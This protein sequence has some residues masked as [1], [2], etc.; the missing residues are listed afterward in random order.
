MEAVG[1]DLHQEG[2][3]QQL[4]EAMAAVLEEAVAEDGEVAEEVGGAGVAAEGGGGWEGDAG[5]RRGS[6]AHHDASDEEAEVLEV[7]ALFEGGLAGGAELREVLLEEGVDLVGDRD[8]LS[9]A[10]ELLEE[11]LEE[12]A[13][14]GDKQIVGHGE[15]FAG[16]LGG[17]EGIAV[18]VAA[19]R[20]AEADELGEIA[21]GVGGGIIVHGDGRAYLRG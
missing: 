14:V 7:E 12:T 6:E 13:V 9:G 2:I 4:G 15:G 19:D 3:D 8:L 5:L 1:S 20:G 10:A 21:D 17:D 11:V 16:G 18:A